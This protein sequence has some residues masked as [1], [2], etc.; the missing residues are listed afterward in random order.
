MKYCVRHVLLGDPKT[1][2]VQL[3][4][5]KILSYLDINRSCVGCFGIAPTRNFESE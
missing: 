1:L 5:N 3:W 2:E 4:S